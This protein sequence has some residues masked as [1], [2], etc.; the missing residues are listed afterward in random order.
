[1]RVVVGDPNTGKV[2]YTPPGPVEV[3]VLA[4]ALVEWLNSEDALDLMPAVQA[5]VAHRQLPLP[6]TFT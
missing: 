5:G 1:M 4:K 3:P 6:K 2:T